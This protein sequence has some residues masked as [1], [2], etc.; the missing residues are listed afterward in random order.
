MD[1]AAPNRYEQIR[2]PAFG[3]EGKFAREV[4]V[5]DLVDMHKLGEQVFCIFI[6]FLTLG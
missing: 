1:V 4:R 2:E 6:E 5:I 3:G